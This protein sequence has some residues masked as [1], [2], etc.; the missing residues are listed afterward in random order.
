MANYSALNCWTNPDLFFIFCNLVLKIFRMKNVKEIRTS[1][2][3]VGGLNIRLRV[4]Q[5]GEDG[6]HQ[7][8]VINL[9][10][11]GSEK[12]DVMKKLCELIT[13]CLAGSNNGSTK[14]KPVKR[15]FTNDGS[16]K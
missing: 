3:L 8:V 10:Q 14:V 12:S 15:L 5:N 9:N 7:V 6:R 4:Y 16:G 1:D 11:F 13:N 2:R